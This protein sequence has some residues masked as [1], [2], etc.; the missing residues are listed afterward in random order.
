MGVSSKGR[1]HITYKNQTYVWW[2][3]KNEDDMDRIWLNII[4]DDK[5]IN[6]AY[7][8]GEGDF[9][10]I[11]RGRYFQGKKTS[12]CWE[13]YYH[14]MKELPMV[15]TPQIVYELIAWAVDGR[16]AVKVNRR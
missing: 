13:Y 1:R 11:S 12:G 15:I 5:S 3:G 8:V 16:D 7:R 2:V 9:H 4:S 14:Q 6:L 10:I